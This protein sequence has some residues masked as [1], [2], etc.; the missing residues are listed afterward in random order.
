MKNGLTRRITKRLPFINKA[1]NGDGVAT[2]LKKIAATNDKA[3]L[4]LLQSKIEGLSANEVQERQALYGLN[5][6]QH[7]KAPAWYKQLLHAFITPF[8]GVCSLS[9]L[10]H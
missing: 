3:C 10:F 6:I 4:R 8:N 2:G 9:Q 5:E 1:G 7:E